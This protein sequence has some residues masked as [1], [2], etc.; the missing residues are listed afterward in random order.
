MYPSVSNISYKCTKWGCFMAYDIF[1]SQQTH[2]KS[3][4]SLIFDLSKILIANFSFV[5]KW[6]PW[7][8]FPNVPYP[9][10]SS[11]LYSSLIII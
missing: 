1:N 8:T 6:I 5:G 7:Y 10:S 2:S 4:L 3:D 9:I 11:N